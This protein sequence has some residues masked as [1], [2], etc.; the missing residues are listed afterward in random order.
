MPAVCHALSQ[1]FS[2]FSVH[3][4]PSE[5]PSGCVC[6]RWHHFYAHYLIDAVRILRAGGERACFE[7]KKQCYSEHSVHLRCRFGG[8]R[9]RVWAY[10]KRRAR[11]WKIDGERGGWARK[12]RKESI[13]CMEKCTIRCDG[14]RTA[15]KKCAI[16][17]EDYRKTRKMKRIRRD[18]YSNIFFLYRY[19]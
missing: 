8:Q 11:V 1:S 10:D 16:G 17:R 12:K 19:F 15:R 14:Y 7:C 3:W 6:G 18:T 13:L 2:A 4:R 5:A 9:R